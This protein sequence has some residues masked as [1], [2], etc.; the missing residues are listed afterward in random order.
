M[1]PKGSFH[2]VAK[3]IGIIKQL[4]KYVND[5]LLSFNMGIYVGEMYSTRKIH[6]LE[7]GGNRFSA[8]DYCEGDTR[9]L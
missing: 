3:G 6:Y 9:Q 7:H 8:Q 5:I 1:P 2:S 4:G